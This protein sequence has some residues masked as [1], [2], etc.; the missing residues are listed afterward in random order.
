MSIKDGPRFSFEFEAEHG[1]HLQFKHEYQPGGSYYVKSSVKKC[2]TGSS[3]KT[4]DV[5]NSKKAARK[6]FFARKNCG[7]K[8]SVR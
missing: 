3:V 2:L 8:A 6:K 1:L 5:K 4:V 7:K